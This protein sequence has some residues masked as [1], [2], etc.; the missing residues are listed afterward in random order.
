MW[1]HAVGIALWATVFAKLLH[2]ARSLDLLLAVLGATQ[3][4]LPLLLWWVRPAAYIRWRNPI[5]I[6]IKLSSAIIGVWQ[7]ILPLGIQSGSIASVL[8]PECIVWNK[9][10][11]SFETSRYGLCAPASVR[12]HWL[13][14]LQYLSS[15]FPAQNIKCL[16]TCRRMHAEEGSLHMLPP[17]HWTTRSGRFA[18][19]SLSDC[20][21][22]HCRYCFCYTLCIWATYLVLFFV[23]LLTFLRLSMNHL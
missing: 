19:I 20:E 8:I 17:Y 14:V 5:N 12:R 13:A 21:L 9:V 3:S 2:S 16:G 11:R 4:S 7:G 1:C 10:R 6:F 18:A 23:R 22:T 15:I